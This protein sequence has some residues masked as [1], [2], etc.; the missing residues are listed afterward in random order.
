[1][2][3]CTVLGV[4]LKQD[5]TFKD[6]PS[7]SRVFRSEIGF[8]P[9][10]NNQ[11]DINQFFIN[12]LHAWRWWQI[13]SWRSYFKNVFVHCDLF[14][15][16]FQISNSNLWKI[17]INSFTVCVR[18]SHSPFSRKSV[19]QHRKH[20]CVSFIQVL[21]KDFES[22]SLTASQEWLLYNTGVICESSK[23][24]NR[25]KSFALLRSRSAN[26]FSMF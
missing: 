18:L 13:I 26:D 15:S 17:I 22:Y 5:T 3:V 2:Y 16:D 8:R 11:I 10:I 14:D 24:W 25:E 6:L 12:S 9:N 20:V 19:Y 4:R 21:W 7:K 23:S 1:M